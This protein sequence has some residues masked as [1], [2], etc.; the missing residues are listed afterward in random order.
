[1]WSPPLERLLRGKSP[2]SPH[3][4]YYDQTNQEDTP[5]CSSVSVRAS[6]RLHG[7][8]E[9]T[10]HGCG[11]TN[12]AIGGYLL[13]CD[14]CRRAYYCGQNCFNAHLVTHQQLCRTNILDC[15][16]PQRRHLVDVLHLP[17]AASK[18]A[19]DSTATGTATV[20]AET[21]AAVHPQPI[22]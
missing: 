20:A 10:C 12:E 4:P 8:A 11:V 14:T 19:A 2:S 7:F 9:T 5:P 3:R 13:Q 6:Q 1:M 21:V 17:N 16:E 18:C 22:K 15:A